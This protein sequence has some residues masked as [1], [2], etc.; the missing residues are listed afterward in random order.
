MKFK[1]MSANMAVCVQAV[2]LGYCGKIEAQYTLYTDN[3]VGEAPASNSTTAKVK[4][5]ESGKGESQVTIW[6]ENFEGQPVVYS[7]NAVGKPAETATAQA[8]GLIDKA[9]NFVVRKKYPE[10]LNAVNQLEGMK[11]TPKQQKAVDALKEQI[12][13]LMVAQTTFEA[14]NSVGELPGGQK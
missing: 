9:I 8:Q 10:A 2:L 5:G 11:L 1:T 13:K 4:L 12:Q 14:T 6:T 7:T 3:F